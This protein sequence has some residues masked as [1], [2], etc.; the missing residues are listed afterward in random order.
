MRENITQAR[1]R[2]FFTIEVA[3][4][5]RMRGE[6]IICVYKRPDVVVL[7]GAQVNESVKANLEIRPIIG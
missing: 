2:D 5:L 7:G 6:T 3:M 4:L 1:Q